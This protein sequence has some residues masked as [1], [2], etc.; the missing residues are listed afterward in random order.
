MGRMYP[1]KLYPK[2][3]YYGY[4]KAPN[5]WQERFLGLPAMPEAMTVRQHWAISRVRQLDHYLASHAV[6]STAALLE[7]SLYDRIT[8]PLTID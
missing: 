1:K 4:S 2:K 8:A 7:Y 3:R 6:G 5:R